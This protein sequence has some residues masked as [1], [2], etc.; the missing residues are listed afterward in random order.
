MK[1]TRKYLT[2]FF[3]KWIFQSLGKN[4]CRLPYPFQILHFGKDIFANLNRTSTGGSKNQ[5]CLV[6]SYKKPS[7]YHRM[8]DHGYDGPPL[9]VL[10]T[11]AIWQER[12]KL[13]QVHFMDGQGIFKLSEKF[14]ISDSITYIEFMNGVLYD[15]FQAKSDAAGLYTKPAVNPLCPQLDYHRRLGMAG[16]HDNAFNGLPNLSHLSLR[17][18]FQMGDMEPAWLAEHIQSFR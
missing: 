6:S 17:G 15:K 9:E 7:V 10:D 16:I 1:K 12:T 2:S 4:F 5:F 14:M 13:K 8:W 18:N 11:G 3:N